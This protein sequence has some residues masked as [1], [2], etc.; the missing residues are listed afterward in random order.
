MF[1]M[2]GKLIY[3]NNPHKLIVDVDDE[4]GRYYRSLIPKSHRIQKPM[5]P[6]HISTVRKEIP[7]NISVWNKYQNELITFNYENFIYNDE[8]YYW[9][10]VSSKRLEDIRIELG[11][12]LHSDLTKSP[13]GKHKFHLTIANIKH[14]G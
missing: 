11:L 12:P 2:V 8:T 3:S 6:S 7:P 14:L 9:L 13:D 4:L 1:S 10:N 5:Y